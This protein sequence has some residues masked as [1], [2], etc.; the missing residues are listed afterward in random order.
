VAG[1]ISFY[2]AGRA[3]FLYGMS[4]DIHR[5]KMPNYL[6]Q[7]KAIRSAKAKECKYYDLWGA[8]DVFT[9]NDPM[10]GVYRFKKGLGGTVVRNIGAY[11]LPARPLL[12][13]LYTQFLPSILALLRRQGKDRVRRLVN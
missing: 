3:W 1:L 11:D 4:R 9:E 5:R 13:R 10:W 6:L 2:F 12:Y 8:P 7:W